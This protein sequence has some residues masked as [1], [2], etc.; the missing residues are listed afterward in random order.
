MTNDIL[1][2]IKLI[3]KSLS[4]DL[5]KKE[6]RELNDS[7]PFFGHCYVATEALYHLL[8]T[9]KDEFKPC[10][11]RDDNDIVHWWLQN[12]TTDEILDVTSEQYHLVGKFPPYEKGKG[13]G[14]LT[15][16]PS[17]R[18]TILIDRVKTKLAVDDATR[19][20]FEMK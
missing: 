17:K 1:R 5:L 3:Q 6:Y 20:K 13:T 15:K 11:G 10:C 18:T 14:F 12:K 7:N 9:E 2:Y 4:K 8:D 19:E 16:S